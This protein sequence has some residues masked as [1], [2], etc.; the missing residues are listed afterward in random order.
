[1]DFSGVHALQEM[2]KTVFYRRNLLTVP[3]ILKPRPGTSLL[4]RSAEFLGSLE[5]TLSDDKEIFMAPAALGLGRGAEVQG[6]LA[7]HGQGARARSA[8]ESW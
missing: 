1:M 2:L 6:P 7:V 4:I 8:S 5:L 3:V